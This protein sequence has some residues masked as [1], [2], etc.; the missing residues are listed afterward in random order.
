METKN[1]Q[2]EDN[3]R[4]E[5][6]GAKPSGLVP[7]HKQQ[8][9]LF[10]I[11][12]ILI[13]ILVIIIANVAGNLV[14]KHEIRRME[15]ADSVQEKATKKPT[16]APTSAPTA[17]P[18]SQ[19]ELNPT[20][21]P[22]EKSL[23]RKASGT[24]VAGVPDGETVSYNIVSIRPECFAADEGSLFYKDV[25]CKSTTSDDTT[26]WIYMSNT[27]YTTYFDSAAKLQQK[28][29]LSYS[30]MRFEEGKKVLGV[31]AN[32]DDLCAGLAD[33]IGRKTILVLQSAE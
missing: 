11:K 17:R 31:Q 33:E 25:V 21:K 3:Q 32:A 22:P 23:V 1:H 9:V 6:P 20:E 13:T 18:L 4:A 10:M 29:Y 19:S 27:D 5:K 16:A 14:A 7:S 26:L 24:T 15:K 2:N 12:T 8:F 28:N 30:E